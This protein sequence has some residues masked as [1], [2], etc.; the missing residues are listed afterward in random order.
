MREIIFELGINAAETLIIIDFMTRYLGCKYHDKRRVIGFAA[1]WAVSF[2]ELSAM[3]HHVPFE[4]IG[5]FIPIAINFVYA[6]LF[7]NGTVFLKLWIS[8]LIEII[9]LTIAVGT[10]LIVCRI[11][12]Y[13]PNDM[14]TVFNSTRVISV[15]ITKLILFYTTRVLLRNKYKNPIDA[16]DWIMLILIPLISVVSLSALML[17]AMR[18]ADITG[19]VL[20]GMSGILLA[21]IVTY[22]LFSTLNRNYETKLKIRLLEQSSENA[23]K[24]LE[25]AEAFVQQMKSARHDIQNQLLI[26]SDYLNREKYEQAKSHIDNLT[27]SYLPN[28]QD[29]INSDNEAFNAVVNSKIAVCGSKDIY[30]GITEMKGALRDFNAVDTGI[31]FGNLLD[32]A[33]EAAEKTTSGR[34]SVDVGVKGSYLSVLVT[35]SINGTVLESNAELQTTKGDKAM[36][37][38]GIES[39]NAIVKKYDGMIQFFEENKEFCCHILLDRDQIQKYR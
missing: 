31:L 14:L 5:V 13:D 34:I 4:G 19:Y 38:I 3:N 2:A 29:F 25:N 27:N 15:I 21:D 6:L 9:M 30:I 28:I 33:I 17:A 12:K 11:F 24:N 23:V 37:G 20:C 35:N 32:N 18:R 1:A 16:Q 7:L 26:I 8:A 22:Y 39:I 36:H 10:N